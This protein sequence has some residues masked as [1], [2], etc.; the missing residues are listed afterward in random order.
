M[1][2]LI[3]RCLKDEMR[4]DERIVVFG[5]DVADC[6]RDEYLKTSRSKQ[7]RRLQTHG[8]F[9]DGVWQRPRIQFTARRSNIIGRAVGMAERGLKPWSKYSFSITYGLHAAA[10]Q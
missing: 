7:G 10:S 6:S 5:E 1:A 2:D 9:T 3:N 8:R 4:R